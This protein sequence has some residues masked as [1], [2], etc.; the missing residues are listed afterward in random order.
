MKVFSLEENGVQKYVITSPA[1]N[2]DIVFDDRWTF[3]GDFNNPTFEP[4]MLVEYPFENPETGHVRE[5]FF[6]RNGKIQ[7][8]SDCHHDMAGKTVDMIDC[9]WGER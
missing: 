3:N 6:V 2:M 5:H 1:T 9:K 8:L 7:Y 4:S